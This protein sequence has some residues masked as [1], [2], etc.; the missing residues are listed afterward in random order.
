MKM[1]LCGWA[2]CN[3]LTAGYY[4]DEHAKAAKAK[5]EAREIYKGT[6][7]KFSAAYHG[8]YATSRWRAMRN[9]FLKANPFC[10]SC[11]AAATVADHVIPHRG[12]EALFFDTG[13]LQALCARCHSR[14]TLAENA[15]F[16]R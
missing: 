5:R 12:D 2:G 6:R 8:L 9:A 4:C 11:G 13:N 16:N 3:K 7:R 1:K 10:V 14:K 15:G